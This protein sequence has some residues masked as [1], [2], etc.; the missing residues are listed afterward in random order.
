MNTEIRKTDLPLGI[1]ISQIAYLLLSILGTF[2]FIYVLLF[3][4]KTNL[5]VIGT[6]VMALFYWMLFYGTYK[7]RNWVVIPVL[8]VSAIAIIPNLL[9]ILTET[10]Q[11]LGEF[12]GKAL[13]ILMTMFYLFQIYIFSRSETKKFFKEKGTTLI[14]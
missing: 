5:E 14:S 10:P 11:T 4:D 9:L 1:E 3:S 7:I 12:F 2:G 6:G 8:V 13:S